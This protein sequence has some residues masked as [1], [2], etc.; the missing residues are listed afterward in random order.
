MDFGRKIKNH[1][2]AI[3]MHKPVLSLVFFILASNSY[4]FGQCITCNSFS[5]ALKKPGK[6]KSIIINSGM[7]EAVDSVPAYIDTFINLES[8]Y[9]TDQQINA[10]PAG[11][12]KLGKLKELS[13]GGCKLTEV[14]E[15]IFAMKHLTGVILFYNAFSEEYKA[16][17]IERFKK[18]LPDTKL[19]IE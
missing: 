15:F 9:L 19:E 17:L 2:F 13:F 16:K 11:I 8:L 18:E 5:E 12:S 7:H 10:I 4:I 3:F 6:V 14:P 1:I